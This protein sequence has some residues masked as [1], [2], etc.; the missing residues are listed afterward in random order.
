MSDGSD[1]GGSQKKASG[2]D[3]PHHGYASTPKAQEGID[4]L[5]IELYVD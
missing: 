4:Q 1:D 3:G 5:E 2:G